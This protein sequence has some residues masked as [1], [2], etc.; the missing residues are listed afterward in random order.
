MVFSIYVPFSF[1]AF[2]FARI[3]LFVQEKDTNTFQELR[4]VLNG[5]LAGQSRKK[6]HPNGKNQEKH[7][8]PWPWH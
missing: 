6:P 3:N 1:T 4:G 8:S 2:V 7:Q 5:R